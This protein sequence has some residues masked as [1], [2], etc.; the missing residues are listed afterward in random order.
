[1]AVT[2]TSVP[3]LGT[4]TGAITGTVTGMP[5]PAGT[6]SALVYG[7]SDAGVLVGP[8]S[9][10]AAC[11]GSAVA[12]TAG[13]TAGTASVSVPFALP[14]GVDANTIAAFQLVVYASAFNGLAEVCVTAAGGVLALPNGLPSIASAYAE[15]EAPASATPSP[16]GT[17]PGTPS[18]PV[19]PT[20]TQSTGFIAGMETPISD[21]L[22]ESSAGSA[23]L[24]TAVAGIAVVAAVRLAV[25]VA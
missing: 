10:Q 6:Y 15:R 13:G 1:M 17:P 21:P 5:E 2:V 7:V 18:A 12:L 11:A 8:L 4:N 20:M 25:R 14:P 3:L 16:A 24:I 23:V 9:N 22:E 19:T